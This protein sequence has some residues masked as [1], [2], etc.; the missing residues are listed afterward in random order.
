MFDA[1]RF[2][3]SCLPGRST[4]KTGHLPPVT[5]HPPG[6]AACR[7]RRLVHR[8]LGEVGSL[9]RGIFPAVN[10]QSLTGTIQ[11][12]HGCPLKDRRSERKQPTVK[13]DEPRQGRQNIHRE[14]HEIREN[15]RSNRKS[16]TSL[17]A[18]CHLLSSICRPSP[19]SSMPPRCART[20]WTASATVS[21]IAFCRTI[22]SAR[23][24]PRFESGDMSPH[25]TA[26]AGVQG[27]IA[28]LRGKRVT[29]WGRTGNKHTEWFPGPVPDRAPS[30]KVD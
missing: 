12:N 26:S 13:W 19:R 17:R 29:Y 9:L 15:F 4:A 14:T 1:P 10:R 2:S 24:S 25:S 6:R 21:R 16:A 18:A 7:V 30:A 5:R 11:L 22:W 3:K 8:S 20:S 23:T 27:Y 28:F